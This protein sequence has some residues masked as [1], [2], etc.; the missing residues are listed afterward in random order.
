MEISRQRIGQS[1]YETFYNKCYCCGGSG[2]KKT[3]SITIH[4][5]ISDIKGI[6]AIEHVDDL[7]I[8]IDE[9]FFKE[10]SQEINKKINLINPKFKIKFITKYLPKEVYE[11][12][13]DLVNKVKDNTKEILEKNKSEEKIIEKSYRRKIKKK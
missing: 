9:Y 4:N 7:E 10:N 8:Y 12:D 13:R 3:N 1:I 11:I 2:F 6:N 5:I